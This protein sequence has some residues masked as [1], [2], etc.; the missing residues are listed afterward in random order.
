[1]QK[2]WCSLRGIKLK[3]SNIL[4]TIQNNAKSNAKKERCL[5]RGIKL[6][7][8]Q[9]NINSPP[10][11]V[12]KVLDNIVTDEDSLEYSILVAK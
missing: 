8:I 12:F 9:S 5:L 1:M 6:N 4:K 2:E 3:P 10:T 7:C 11:F